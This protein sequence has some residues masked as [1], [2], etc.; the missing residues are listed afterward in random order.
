MNAGKAVF[1]GIE[2]G[3]TPS[4]K[5]YI[6]L[7][8]HRG[9]RRGKSIWHSNISP[10]QEYG[11][12]ARSDQNDW[13]DIRGHYWS[14]ASSDGLTPTGTARQVLAK[15]PCISNLS[16]PWHGY[17]VSPKQTGDADAPADELVGV[18]LDS[19]VITRTF[20]RRIRDRRV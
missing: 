6:S 8:A 19:K 15:H 5:M 10:M 3:P 20:A 18:W 17:P 16:D 9:A 4:G 12:F 13:F 7:N 1:G 11:L 2:F 14:F